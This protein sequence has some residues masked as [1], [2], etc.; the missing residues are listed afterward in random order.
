MSPYLCFKEL[1]PSVGDALLRLWDRYPNYQKRSS[2][3]SAGMKT[4]LKHSQQ[5]K[6]S[7]PQLQKQESGSPGSR[8]S[9]VLSKDAAGT[10]KFGEVR[11]DN[12]DQMG[13]EG[14]ASE[15]KG[16]GSGSSTSSPTSNSPCTVSSGSQESYNPDLDPSPCSSSSSSSHPHGHP[17]TAAQGYL[18]QGFSFQTPSSSAASI[19][20]HGVFPPN[21]QMG[22]GFNQMYHMG[23]M[24]AA[25]LPS[26][27]SMSPRPGMSPVMILQRGAGGSPSQ[28]HPHPGFMGQGFGGQAPGAYQGQGAQGQK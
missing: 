4:I 18:S 15:G 1:E 24:G 25:V 10:K 28:V 6:Q 20:S 26:Q 8:S 3:S 19:I 5:S 21:L 22:P 23:P 16:F 17:D 13:P 12:A 27:S 2:P 7:N 9:K 11:K 14:D